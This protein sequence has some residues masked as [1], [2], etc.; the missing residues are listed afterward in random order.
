MW[1]GTLS[2]RLF[3]DFGND[4]AAQSEHTMVKDLE[5]ISLSKIL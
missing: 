5:S 4:L 1:V 3:K 2:E